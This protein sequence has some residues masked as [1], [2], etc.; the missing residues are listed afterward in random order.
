MRIRFLGLLF[1]ALTGG[2]RPLT[3]GS[4]DT[5]TSPPVAASQPRIFGISGSWRPKPSHD[6]LWRQN[7]MVLPYAE[8]DSHLITLRNVRDCY[9]RSEHD[10]D[11][12]HFDVE[13]PL[14]DVQTL[15]FIVVPFRATPSLA[16]T[17]LSFG[18]ANGQY[19]V[20][21]V[22]SR[23]EQGETYRP[24]EGAVN[25]YELM[26]VVG[27]ER[28]LIGLR[29]EIRKDDVYLYRTRANPDQVR[30][31]F[32]AAVARVN[33]IARQP[34]FY[35]TLRNNC[36]TNIVAL[37]NQLQPNTIPDDLRIVLPGH[38][39][40]L[41]YDLGLLDVNNPY[42]IAKEVSRISPLARL[43]HGSAEYSKAIRSQ[44]Q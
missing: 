37:I 13:V 12:S 4:L 39:D 3:S 25:G 35:D 42:P 17:M 6:R 14:Y 30:K 28:D 21:S 15:D 8:I 26:W 22:E 29:T 10:Y 19:I 41:L 40:K 16:H 27:T 36:T 24:I 34:E 18:L 7:Q 33:E 2:C 9:Y 23:L 38:S 43:H 31:I 1:L 5:P 44:L 11:V 20:F 32:L